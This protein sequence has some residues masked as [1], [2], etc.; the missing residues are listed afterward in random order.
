ME[1]RHALGSEFLVATLADP[2]GRALERRA[3]ARAAAAG[4]DGRVESYVDE[5][6]K[7]KGKTVSGVWQRGCVDEKRRHRHTTTFF[8]PITTRNPGFCD[9]G[10]KTT[11]KR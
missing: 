3:A 5:V 4:D 9:D 6:Q 11:K 10:G 8:S 1:E 7:K 2:D